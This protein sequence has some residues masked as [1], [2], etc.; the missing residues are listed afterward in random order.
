M[1]IL[2]LTPKVNNEG[3][4][5]KS[6]SVK[7]NY[8]IEN[9]NYSIHILTQN[10]GNTPLFHHFHPQINMDDIAFKGNI[11][12]RFF[13]YK[14]AINQKIND[15]NPDIIVVSDNGLKGYLVPIL[16]EKKL[17]VVFECHGSIFVEEKNRPRW[18]TFLKSKYKTFLGSYFTKF[19]V[20]S[21]ESQK[22][23]KL[24]N[25]V[26]IPNSITVD[27]SKKAQ[28]QATKCIAI[29]RHSYEKGLDRLL[30]IWKE[31]QKLQPNWTLEIYGDFSQN[32]SII[33]LAK[34][35]ELQKTVHFFEPIHDLEE[36]YLSA[37]IMLMT[38]R[39]EGFP[40]AILEANSLGLPVVAYDCPIGPRAIIKD[41]ETGF[42]I[43]DGN[44]EQFVAQ[45]N[46]LMNDVDVRKQ[47]GEKAQIAMNQYNH[48]T[49]MKKWQNLFDSLLLH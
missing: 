14:N 33:E 43:A 16:L 13:S 45:L 15:V 47:I 1:K 24:K 25:S 29:A 10:N 18:I 49:I 7:A 37:S 34:Q 44:K 41:N 6:L 46:R 26:V 48:Q 32:K 4:V 27:S 35:L 42:L 2:Y 36:K 20:L 19:V 40:M 28:L 17:P 22:E 12:S 31:I 30:L 3:G 9:Y 8:F 39:T 23:W 11:I 38:S 5:A 21:D